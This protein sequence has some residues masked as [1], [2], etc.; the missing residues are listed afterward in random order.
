MLSVKWNR[1]VRSSIIFIRFLLLPFLNRNGSDPVEYWNGCHW[2]SISLLRST[3]YTFPI[4]PLLYRFDRHQTTFYQLQKAVSSCLRT[5]HRLVAE[6]AKKEGHTLYIACRYSCHWRAEYNILLLVQLWFEI[7]LKTRMQSEWHHLSII[8]EGLDWYPETI[9]SELTSDG[10]N[11]A[12]AIDNLFVLFVFQKIKYS[13]GPRKPRK[14]SEALERANIRPVGRPH[15]GLMDAT[16]LATLVMH[17]IG[18]GLLF[19]I[20]SEYYHW[21]SAEHTI[22]WTIS[23]RNEKHSIFNYF[24]YGLLN[25]IRLLILIL[26]FS[27]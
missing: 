24:N 8:S 1:K 4:E 7:F 10:L 16:N 26:I 20:A 9:R 12:T 5:I 13:A 11:S 2:K 14:F 25:I 15:S 6:T 27:I 17:L 22:N 18:K 3:N 21:F 23:W 19:G